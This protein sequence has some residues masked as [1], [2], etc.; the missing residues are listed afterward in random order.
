MLPAGDMAE[1]T[2]ER[3]AGVVRGYRRRSLPSTPWF[4]SNDE[5]SLREA[6]GANHRDEQGSRSRRWRRRTG[7]SDER[8]GPPQPQSPLS[9]CTVACPP[10]FSLLQRVP[11]ILV[12]HLLYTRGMIPMS[13]DQLFSYDS[14]SGDKETTG[15][16]VGTVPA[17]GGS[18][19]EAASRITGADPSLRRKVGRT[20]R[21]ICELCDQ[22]RL[23][24]SW[25]TTQ[26]SHLHQYDQD[27]RH[28]QCAPSEV[29]NQTLPS[30]RPAFV[31]I[32]V[33]LSYT[34]SCELYLLDLQSWKWHPS[35]S[36][37]SSNDANDDS[38]TPPSPPPPPSS[39][40]S[41]DEAN[42]RMEAILA[43]RLVSFLMMK[44]D[45]LISSQPKKTSPS[46]R[47]WLTLGFSSGRHRVCEPSPSGAAAAAATTAADGS[48]VCDDVAFTSEAACTRENDGS[49]A[50]RR[51]TNGITFELIQRTRFPL[52][53]VTSSKKASPRSLVVSIRLHNRGDRQ[54]PFIQEGDEAHGEVLPSILE[55]TSPRLTWVSLPTCIKGFRL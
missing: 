45:C 18:A 19:A 20:R 23:L 21:Q 38:R 26:Y 54:H 1:R 6:S 47:L 50:A 36:P 16:G 55:P 7:T 53:S 48:L 30:G 3:E 41:V 2:K 33:G 14:S 17:C 35:S 31:L 32:S 34:R 11:L 40:G 27:D 15:R 9:I 22:W 12:K 10:S 4:P 44:E 39:G 8:T 13:V 5:A 51:E 52:S 25:W 29:P 24:E 37:S 49:E 28:G 42:R 43:R 46:N